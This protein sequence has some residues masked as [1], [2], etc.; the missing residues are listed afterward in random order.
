M[1]LASLCLIC[2]AGVGDAAESDYDEYEV[3]AGF[4]AN[5]IKYTTWPKESFETE[6]SPISV[7]LVGEERRL[8]LVRRVLHGKSIQRRRVEVRR[9]HSLPAKVEAHVLVADGQSRSE[10]SSVLDACRARPILL[11]GD[12]MD[13][14]RAGGTMN[15]FIDKGKLR[16]AANREGIQQ[17]GLTISYHVLKLAEIVKTER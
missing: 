17:A 1:L 5:F 11:V 7:L 3:K 10:R 16:F 4:L 9:V 8:D 15:F 12:T 14:A 13:Y 6:K 2:G